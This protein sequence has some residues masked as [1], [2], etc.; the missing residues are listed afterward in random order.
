MAQH[1][2]GVVA[3]PANPERGQRISIMSAQVRRSMAGA[4]LESLRCGVLSM[5]PSPRLQR[6]G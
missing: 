5:L 2:N 6:A 4:N 3:L 1:N